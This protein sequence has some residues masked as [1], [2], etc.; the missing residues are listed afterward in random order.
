MVIKNKVWVI[1][2]AG[3]G[4]GRA[5]TLE[6]IAKG[7]SVAMVDINEES[8]IETES[9]AGSNSS[10]LSKHT[11]DITNKE[12]VH[13][14]PEEVIKI[15]GTVDGLINNAGIIQPFININELGYDKIEQVLNINFYGSLY[16][17]K[18]FLP[19]LLKRPDAHIANI[20]SL[21]GFMPFPG[22]SIYGASK[23]ALKLVT[24]RT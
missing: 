7:G 19:H 4:L 23:A 18:A 20:S 2:G 24:G 6:I 12:K 5:L 16:M 8:L 9:L 13:N 1:T 11:I 10:K 17:I 14:F 3:S 15:H 21:G 22:Q